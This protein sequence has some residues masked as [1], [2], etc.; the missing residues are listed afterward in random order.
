MSIS[1]VAGALFL[2]VK[3]GVGIVKRKVVEESLVGLLG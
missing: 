1:L 3:F 2:C